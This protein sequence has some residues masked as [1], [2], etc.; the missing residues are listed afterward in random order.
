MDSWLKL[1]MFALEDIMYKDV[2]KHREIEIRLYDEKPLDLRKERK[3]GE[4]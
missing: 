2:E 4:F 3:S 1:K